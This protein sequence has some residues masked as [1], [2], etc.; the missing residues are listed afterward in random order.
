MKI[1]V[2]VIL[3]MFS[4][5]CS[6][7]MAQQGDLE[8]HIQM[9]PINSNPVEI[10]NVSLNFGFGY[11]LYKGDPYNIVKSQTSARNL[12]DD[13]LLLP[14]ESFYFSIGLH[15]FSIDHNEHVQVWM[16]FWFSYGQ[17]GVTKEYRDYFNVF[18]ASYVVNYG[19]VGINTSLKYNLLSKASS[20][21]L[22]LGFSA[23]MIIHAKGFYEIPSVDEYHLI[24][25]YNVGPFIGAGWDLG[26]Q[27]RRVGFELR[28]CFALADMFYSDE[29]TPSP[30]IL[31]NSIYFLVKIYI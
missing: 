17:T 20:P 1:E 31:N 4:V 8:K 10:K 13:D 29:V 6:A 26:K 23:A 27:N 15:P 28:N 12:S 22:S 5:S 3:I 2:I 11:Y 14:G 19:W 16:E 7:L 9:F 25:P 21:F 18:G 30:H 24:R